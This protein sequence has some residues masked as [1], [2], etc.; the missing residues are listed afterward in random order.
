MLS[1]RQI[2]GVVV[3]AIVATLCSC[4]LVFAVLGCAP[5]SPDPAL[6]LWEQPSPELAAKAHAKER[7][8]LVALLVLPT[9]SM[10]P[11]L[12]GGDWAVG[13][14]TAPFDGIKEGDLLL[15]QASWLP[16]S[17]PLVIHA[18]AAKHGEG[19]IMNGIANAHYESGKL[20]MMREDYRAKVI[21]VYT[22]RAK[23]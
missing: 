15:Y 12:T 10:E 4:A 11:F 23:S 13:D 17:S 20:T 16:Q 14:F 7:P 21:R 1:P 5:R 8:G 22:K 2:L 19:W 9:G 18:A 3:W 6:V